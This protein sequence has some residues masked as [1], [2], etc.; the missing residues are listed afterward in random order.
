MII[1]GDGSSR[2]KVEIELNK[3]TSDVYFLGRV[4]PIEIPAL[5]A[6][7]DLHITT[8]EKETRGLTILEA[9][10]SG[11][12][13]IAPRAGGVIENIIDGEN[14]FLFTPQDEEDFINKLQIIINNPNL[15][16][17]MGK[18]GQKSIL[19]YNW[20]E[21]TKNLVEI[22]ENKVFSKVNSIEEKTY[23][24]YA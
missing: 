24:K 11:I 12:P 17:A 10:A 21:T 13:V 16:K 9:F 3:L 5:L 20:D 6:N 1:A 22:W 14:G 19:R 4:D 18:K 23:I 7:C 8:S 2:Q 15:C